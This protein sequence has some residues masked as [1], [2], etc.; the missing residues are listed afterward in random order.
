VLLEGEVDALVE[1]AADAHLE[2]RLEIRVGAGRRGREQ[3][4]GDHPGAHRMAHGH[5]FGIG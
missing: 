4:R 5:S 1:L 2:P 3:E